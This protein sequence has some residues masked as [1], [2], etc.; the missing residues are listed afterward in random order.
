MPRTK[1]AKGKKE[2]VLNSRL[3]LRLSA[4]DHAK[5]SNYAKKNNTAIS[6]LLRDFINSLES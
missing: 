6:K 4:H 1:G 3:V 5:I 2:V